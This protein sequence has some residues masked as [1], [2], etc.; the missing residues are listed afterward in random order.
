VLDIQIVGGKGEGEMVKALVYVDEKGFEE[1]ICKDEY[2]M[3]INKGVKDAIGKGLEKWYV[4]KY[5]RPFVPACEV[6]EEV[7]DPFHPMTVGF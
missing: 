7:L 4:Q 1:G 3:R 2:V 5:I 6:H